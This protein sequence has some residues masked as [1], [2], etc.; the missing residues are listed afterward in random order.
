MRSKNFL[1]CSVVLALAA[2]AG[3][4]AAPSASA[5]GTGTGTGT[6]PRQASQDHAALVAAVAAGR[7]RAERQD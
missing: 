6:G 4:A 3:I 5:D 2:A 1:R 7:L